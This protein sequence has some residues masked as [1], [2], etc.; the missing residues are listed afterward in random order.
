[1]YALA[2]TGEAN[3]FFSQRE[4]LMK[5]FMCNQVVQPSVLRI[6]TSPLAKN[7]ADVES[8]LKISILKPKIR[9]KTR[10]E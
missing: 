2:L 10:Q 5:L 7:F 3:I 4:N 9:I 1:M 6:N 8:D